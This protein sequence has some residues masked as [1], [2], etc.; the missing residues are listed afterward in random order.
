MRYSWFTPLF[1]LFSFCLVGPLFGLPPPQGQGRRQ[2]GHT[3]SGVLFVRCKPNFT[4]FG[5]PTSLI[6]T[7]P[8]SSTLIYPHPPHL[9]IYRKKDEEVRKM[10]HLLMYQP[11]SM[12]PSAPFTNFPLVDKGN[13]THAI[14]WHMPRVVLWHVDCYPL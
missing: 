13:G 14:R 12:S 2:I 8:T 6:N 4:K 10:C 3:K 5:T 11:V 1:Y 7:I 9:I